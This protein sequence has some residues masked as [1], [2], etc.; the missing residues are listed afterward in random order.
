MAG[1]PGRVPPVKSRIVIFVGLM[2]LVGLS[3]CRRGMRTVELPIHDK[4]DTAPVAVVRLEVPTDWRSLVPSASRLEYL[5]PDNKTRSYFR[6]MKGAQS[7][8]ECS[9]MAR[10]YAKEVIGSWGPGTKVAAKEENGPVV[11]FEIK[12]SNPKPAGE[13]IWSRVECRYGVLAIASCA[14]GGSSPEPLKR[15]CTDIVSRFEVLPQPR[16]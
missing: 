6:I 4:P 16:S 14:T 11:D 3:G 1:S 2:S 9:A 7:E 15:R 13:T 10:D 12:R 8:K 5:A